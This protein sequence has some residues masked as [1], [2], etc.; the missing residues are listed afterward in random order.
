MK[1]RV[2]SYLLWEN[3]KRKESDVDTKPTLLLF[4]LFEYIQNAGHFA[5]N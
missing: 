5:K 4:E 1:R 2:M 3:V